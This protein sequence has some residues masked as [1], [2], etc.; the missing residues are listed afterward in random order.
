MKDARC[1]TATDG[2]AIKQRVGNCVYQ[3]PVRADD[4]HRAPPQ[5]PDRAVVV[6]IIHFSNAEQGVYL[7]PIVAG[8]LDELRDVARDESF[9]PPFPLVR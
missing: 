8:V 3:V 2:P 6:A 7:I 4:G 1:L 5:W 9:R